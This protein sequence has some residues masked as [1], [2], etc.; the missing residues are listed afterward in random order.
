MALNTIAIIG[1]D[2]HGFEEKTFKKGNDLVRKL[3]KIGYDV[4][5]FTILMQDVDALSV[6]IKTCLKYFHFVIILSNNKDFTNV[7]NFSSNFD[8]KI[9][10]HSTLDIEPVLYFQRIFLIDLME[11]SSCY[12][13]ILE[14]YLIYYI[15][16]KPLC[17]YIQFN[18]NM[19]TDTFGNHEVKVQFVNDDLLKLT[20]LE[21]DNLLI[22][23]HKIV[24]TMNEDI[25][26]TFPYVEVELD[27]YTNFAKCEEAFKVS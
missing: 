15:K 26:E 19:G 8:W 14:K 10:K 27:N 6:E 1:I 9:L 4:N 11:I 20:A 21:L 2:K 23:E 12:D 5:K 22:T 25:K 17:K 7:E 24:A 18:R 16:P 13:K 3:K